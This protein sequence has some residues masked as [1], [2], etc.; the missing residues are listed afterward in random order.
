[1]FK[2]L[3]RVLL[4]IVLLSLTMTPA[5]AYQ[6]HG[7]SFSPYT[8]GSD[9]NLGA[10]VNEAQLA[11]RLEIVKPY[12]Q[13]VRTFGS[14]LGIEKAGSIAKSQGFKTALGAWIGRDT[15]ANETEITNLINAG[16]AGQADLV[17]VGSEVLLRGDLSEQALLAYINQV[18]QQLPG[19]PVAYAD[20]YSVLIAHPNVINAVDVI[21]ANYYPY[22]EQVPVDQAIARL[23]D[24]HQ[25]MLA[26]AKGK[27]VVVSETGWPSD[28]ASQGNAIASLTNAN[29]YFQKFIFWANANNV[30]YFYFEA[31]DEPYKAKYEGSQGAHWGLWDSNLNLKPGMDAI[32][33]ADIQFTSVPD[34]GS[35][36]DLKGIVLHVQPTDYRV[37][38]YINVSGNWWTKPTAAE[39][40]TTIQL[41]GSWVCDI[42]TGGSDEKATRI[43]AFLIPA[44]Y[45]PPVLLG[46]ATLPT[47]LTNNAIASRQVARSPTPVGADLTI[48]ALTAPTSG[49]AG[50]TLTVSDT[51]KNQGSGEAGAS[52]TKF[53]LSKNT[54]L[55]GTDI[56]LGSRPVPVLAVGAVNSANT[57]LTI[58]VGTAA[59]TY[60]ILAEADSGKV[61]AETNE[62]NN[63]RA[64]GSVAIGPDL[65]ISV[66][67]APASGAAGASLTVSDTTKN[68]GAGEASAS[69][70]KFYLS[71]NTALDGTDIPLG[72]RPVP[73]LTAG[74]VNSANTPLTIPVGTAAGTYY[75]LAEA[76]SGK[77]VAET[78]ENNNVRASGSITIGAD[79]I[80]SALTVPASGGAGGTLTVSDTTKNQGA[81]EAGASTTKF[82]L[83]KNTA[84]DGTDILLGSRA[85]P[86]LVAG[87][88]SSTNTPLTIPVGT[89]A[90]TYYILAEADG[91]KVVAE[92]NENNNVRASGS[93]AIGPDLIVS[94]KVPPTGGAGGTITVSCTIKN[95]GGGAAGASTIKFYLSKNTALD[96][97]DISLGSGVVP[98]LPPGA[99]VSTN[100]PLTIPA[101]TAVGTYYIL[102]EVDS[103]NVV[104]ETNETNNVRS[105]GA[106]T[107]GADLIVSALTAPANGGAGST[108]TI[109]DTTKN[110]GAGDAI[111]ST[112]NFYLSKNTAWDGTDILLG[113][114]PVPALL[115]GATDSANTTLTIPVETAAG[116]YYLLAKADSG[117][118]VPETNE[119]N[120][121]RASGSIAIG[122]NLVISVLTAPASGAAGGTLTVSDTTKNQGGGEAGAST[123]SFYLSKNTALDGTDIPL[124]SRPVSA[125][126][127]GAVSSAS[128][129]LTI[130]A[131]TAAG[132]YYILAKADSGNA[133]AETNE[134]NNIAAKSLT[135]IGR[136]EGNWCGKTNQGGNV[137]FTAVNNTVGNFT[138]SMNVCGVGCTWVTKTIISMPINGTDFSDIAYNLDLTGK[139]TSATASK[140]TWNYHDI[141]LG[142]SG[143]GTWSATRCN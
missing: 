118:V 51:T 41:D 34:Y 46:V 13:W 95:Q 22:W 82:Y 137:T 7:L 104:G 31:F 94:C 70:T 112:T 43:A 24:M 62:N 45:S 57:P 3:L 130:P 48:S 89:A 123:T 69:T 111:A 134:N 125:L 127:A 91:G 61:V 44:S 8:D 126:A 5:V 116:T 17:I 88:A 80:I 76:D 96:G 90:G 106:L 66:L 21:F 27:P 98:A 109:S 23:Q 119:T 114:R 100:T 37:A 84:L 25:R 26:A 129:M 14:T 85:V 58:P 81:G 64:S 9:P 141:N 11:A 1:M 53:Y 60:Y 131:A 79:L 142:G 10:Q 132:T 113:S 136:L 115:P 74:A 71:K 117:G 121:V 86:A 49:G 47:E 77:V 99:T 32:L 28:G 59:G 83:S 140:G 97:T 92:T 52:T 67:T 87:A 15:A 6:L 18:K 30:D 143:K 16:K 50:G 42:T 102:A 75:I 138:I 128:T 65:V 122:P 55:D 108:L 73:V 4:S 19:I 12:T 36:A 39:P 33:N 105:C 56:P 40:I 68:Q 72:S 103:G 2:I 54:A 78:N 135:V 20:I 110:Q 101:D 63:V 35:S 93:V 120:N 107:I 29:Q 38:V 139:F 133:V 124:G